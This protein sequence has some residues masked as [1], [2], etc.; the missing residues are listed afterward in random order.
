MKQIPQNRPK[1]GL[2]VAMRQIYVVSV[3]RLIDMQRRG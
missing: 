3:Y 2:V 1:P